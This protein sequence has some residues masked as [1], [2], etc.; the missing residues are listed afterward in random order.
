MD[1]DNVLK[2]FKKDPPPRPVPVPK[3]EWRQ[4]ERLLRSTVDRTSDEA[5]TLS[6]LIHHV[7]VQK[8]LL[9][10]ENKGLRDA[11]TTKKNHN[12]KGRV[13]DLQ[14]REEY[15]G[16]AVI[17]SPRKLRE[18]EARDKVRRDEEEAHLI[19]KAEEKEQ[20]ATAKA[21]KHQQVEQRKKERAEKAEKRKIEIAEKAAKRKQEQQERDYRKALQ[22][23]QTGKRK[24]SEALAPKAK[25]AQRSG[26][27]GGGSRWVEAPSAAQASTSKRGRTIKPRRIFE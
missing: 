20:R 16:G 18:A 4:I 2:R 14:Q 6:N 3:S 11:L 10:D 22:T 24:A 15:H 5:K 12:K 19:Q 9:E 7:T 1:P 17:W 25:R 27:D 13:L 8:E 21:Y 23:S 26:D